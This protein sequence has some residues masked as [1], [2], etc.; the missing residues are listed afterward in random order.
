[1]VAGPVFREV[2]DKLMAVS[3]DKNEML[4][5]KSPVIKADSSTYYYAGYTPAVKEVY[6]TLKYTYKDSTG[7]NEW[8]R[9][10]AY[11]Y[12]PVLNKQTITKQVGLPANRWKL[13]RPFLKT[14]PSFSN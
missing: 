6:N 8:S 12:Q 4:V 7:S 3:A 9:V 1:M 11:N 13:V 5:A 2:S 14:N 10:Y